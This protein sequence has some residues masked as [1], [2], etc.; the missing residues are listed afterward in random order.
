[1]GDGVIDD[2]QVTFEV[3]GYQAGGESGR[4]ILDSV[5]ISGERSTNGESGI[6]NETETAV[7]YG[8]KMASMSYEGALN[9]RAAEMLEDMWQNA[10]E[11][12]E[13]SVVAGDVLDTRAA[14][15][16]WN[17]FEVNH[18][19]DSNSTVSLEAKLRGVDI[20]ANP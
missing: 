13:V 5:T 19:D 12:K 1:M 18:E 2:A 20:E 3:A 6:G 11:P 17:S 15:M 10:R 4:I 9:R 16:D 7:G 14:K 8:T